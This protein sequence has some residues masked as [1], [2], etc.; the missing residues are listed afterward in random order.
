MALTPSEL[1]ESQKLGQF[2][3]ELKKTFPTNMYNILYYKYKLPSAFLWYTLHTFYSGLL[4]KS[5]PMGIQACSQWFPES[6]QSD[7][8][9]SLFT[10][11]LTRPVYWLWDWVSF[12]SIGGNQI[13]RYAD[14][15]MI[16]TSIFYRFQE[17]TLLMWYFPR[18]QNVVWTC[19]DPADLLSIMT[20]SASCQSMFLMRKYFSLFG[21]YLFPSWSYQLW[22]KLYG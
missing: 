11:V 1:L 8:Q 14:P 20:A 9:Y 17:M 6:C 16:E 15:W 21:Q 10:L 13:T 12:L 18:W 3:K 4:W 2:R 5:R 22:S 7:F 19:T